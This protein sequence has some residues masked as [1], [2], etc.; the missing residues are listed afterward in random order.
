V[1]DAPHDPASG[2]PPPDDVDRRFREIVAGLTG[3]P[4]PEAHSD[5]PADTTG[6]SDGSGDTDTRTAS[7]TAGGRAPGA[8]D[9]E[10]GEPATIPFDRRGYAVPPAGVAG[11]PG[12]WRGSQGEDAEED[13][14]FVPAPPPPLPAGDLHFWAIL[15]GLTVGPLLLVLSYVLPLLDETWGWVGIGMAVAGFVLLV[16][17]QPRDHREDDWGAQV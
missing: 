12:R 15:V 8:G 16:L 11:V 4:E 9:D 5:P 14:H 10:A 3:P 13:D 7:P 17:R 6:D 2:G 1:S